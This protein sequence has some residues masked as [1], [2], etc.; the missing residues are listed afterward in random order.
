MTDCNKEIS[1]P[2]VD[3]TCIEC[4]EIIPT[5]CVT[6][7]EADPYIKWG[8]GEVLTS[9]LKKISAFIKKLDNLILAKEYVALLSQSGTDSPSVESEMKSISQT[10][11][12]TYEGVGEYKLTFSAPVL[13]PLTTF[14]Y[15]PSNTPST[16]TIDVVIVT[17]TIVLIR[18]YDTS[19]NL[20]DGLLGKDV[21]TIKIKR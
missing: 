21:L 7:S 19:G 5:N 16:H 18:T 9:I 20:S 6:A 3:E 4:C 17:S 13:D 12:Y 2:S 10:A 8:K 11:V 14:I 15:M 1:K